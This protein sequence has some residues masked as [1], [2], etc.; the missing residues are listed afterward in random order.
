MDVMDK[1]GA[2]AALLSRRLILAGRREYH[3]VICIMRTV[4]CGAGGL[5]AAFHQ[6]T[7]LSGFRA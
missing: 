2:G 7:A 1:S 4:L 5:W 3:N 6:R